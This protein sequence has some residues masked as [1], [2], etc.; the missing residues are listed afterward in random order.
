[1]RWL[2]GKEFIQICADS[3][4]EFKRNEPLRL[5]GASAFF[6]YVCAS[7]YFNNTGSD[8]WFGIRG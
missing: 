8:Y 5:A 3:F 7:A 2:K 1:M 6:Y 4:D